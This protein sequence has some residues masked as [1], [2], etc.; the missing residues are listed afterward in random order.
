MPAGRSAS[1]AL[2]AR[3]RA[4]DDAELE[5]LI[6]SRDVRESGIRDFFDLADALLDRTSIQRALARLDRPTLGA[7]AM[8]GTLGAPTLPDVAARLPLDDLTERLA[9]A[10]KLQLLDEDAGRYLVWEP[11][12]EQLHGW[13]EDGLPST[14]DLIKV[15]PP[16]ALDAVADVDRD[17]TDRAAADRAFATITQIAELL[18]ELERLPARPLARGGLGLPEMKRLAE[19]T[20]VTVDDVM[21]L[22][23]VAE[24]AALVGLD[25]PGWLPTEAAQRWLLAPAKERWALLAQAWLSNLG[26]DVRRLLADRPRSRWGASLGE[27][28]SWLYPAGSDWMQER[29]RITRRDAELLG[30][31]AG[32]APSSAG[33]L[34]ITDGA[35]AASRVMGPLFPS[36]VE[37]VYVQHDLSVVS[38]GPLAPHLD[39]R[40][41]GIADV[42]QRGI[43]AT[44]RISGSSLSRGLAAGE[45]AESI[46]A[47]LEQLSLTGI[48]QPL[49]YLIKDT[50]ARFG[51]LRV[52]PLDGSGEPGWPEYGRLSAVR[53]DDEHLLGLVAVD[54]SLASL[55]LVRGGPNR[56]LSRFDQGV[57]YWAMREAHYPVVAEDAHGT[58]IILR[59]RRATPAATTPPRGAADLVAALRAST[60]GEPTETGKAWL[61]RQL[62]VAI[63]GRLTV[64]VSV[65]MP[66]GRDV[67]YLLEPTGLAGGRLR[68]RDRLADLERTLPLSHITAVSPS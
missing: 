33:T 32:E 52:A 10:V 11:V 21:A 56:L 39:A 64:T 29:S 20:Q 13:P 19:A 22:H 8:V 51:S 57:V 14:D 7:I 47:M 23:D 38:P 65:R 62:D 28:V 37:R 58:P 9:A 16:A 40:L 2:A 25:R 60:L 49:D 43:A 27:Y 3:L 18:A 55:G 53:S 15:T 48:P 68:G 41:R 31:V 5:E 50:A 1:L 17:A 12:T 44:Y 36:E 24:R 66:D 45:S 34:L 35:D 67:D 59:P 4:L 63:K 6:V 61:A 26:P 30:V 46:H 54:V 42:E